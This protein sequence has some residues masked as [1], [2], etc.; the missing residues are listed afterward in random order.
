MS[1]S[2]GTNDSEGQPRFVIGQQVADARSAEERH[3]QSHPD[4]TSPLNGTHYRGHEF[5]L[6]QFVDSPV[7]DVVE[8]LCRRFEVA[9]EPERDRLRAAL[10]ADDLYTLV[11]FARRSAVRS[12]RG[13]AREP[14]RLGML[15][16]EQMIDRTRLDH[17]DALVAA[18]IVRHALNRIDGTPND[19]L[20]EK[21]LMTE[22]R[23]PD[24]RIGIADVEHGP[25]A[26]VV[27][28]TPAGLAMM[29][30]LNADEYD[31]TGV[32]VGAKVPPAWL[33][34]PARP[35]F[36][37]LLGRSPAIIR[38]NAGRRNFRPFA[39]VFLCYLI[40]LA[41]E[42]DGARWDELWADP[43]PRKHAVLTVRVDRLAALV[44]VSST[45]ADVPNPE[46]DQSL[47]RWADPV[48]AILAAATGQPGGV[49]TR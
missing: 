24:G 28:L 9:D 43:A 14:A 41:E 29:A 46:S 15:A 25:T 40:E 10:T 4:V 19:E 49:G 22:V 1:L 12:L 11:T 5:G 37:E 44:V 17:R 6:L 42:P 27:D 26:G 7:D 32:T 47:S 23:L 21:W 16:L 20:R 38:V 45:M 31:A 36:E 35:E 33:P 34:P 39:S 18:G 2:R 3:R 13:D 8:A 48:R 30:L